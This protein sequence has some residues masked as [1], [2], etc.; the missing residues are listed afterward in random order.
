M[1]GYDIK[2]GHNVGSNDRNIRT[3][4]GCQK[5]CGISN[6][7]RS[8]AFNTRDE[9]NAQRTDGCWFKLKDLD[10]LEIYE[11]ENV[12]IGRKYC[13]GTNMKLPLMPGVNY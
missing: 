4:E 10:E 13:P 1:E 12:T 8:F 5:A 9:S 11:R 3:K 6:L 2:G 7:C